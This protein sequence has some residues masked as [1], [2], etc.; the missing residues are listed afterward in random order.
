MLNC[1]YVPFNAA[2]SLRVELCVCA[3]LNAAG[4]LRVELYVYVC[5]LECCRESSGPY[6]RCPRKRRW[7]EGDKFDL[8]SVR[9]GLIA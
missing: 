5:A 3:L 2:G 7:G 9:R 8:A 1:A 4:S 6:A